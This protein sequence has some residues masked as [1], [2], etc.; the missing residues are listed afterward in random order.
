MACMAG[1]HTYRSDLGSTRPAWAEAWRSTV[2]SS[3]YY[4]GC[5]CW[6]GSRDEHVVERPPCASYSG[7]AQRA[8]RDGARRRQARVSACTRRRGATGTDSATGRTRAGERERARRRRDGKTEPATATVGAEVARV[9][10]YTV[11]SAWALLTVRAMRAAPM[12]GAARDAR[13][14]LHGKSGLRRSRE[15]S[16][17]FGRS[18]WAPRAGEGRCTFCVRLGCAPHWSW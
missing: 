10:G 7:G 8:P 16:G 6:V 5:C 12:L 9:F 15:I 3:V 13:S 2:G 11:P 4:L 14:R 1:G 17:D 18:Q